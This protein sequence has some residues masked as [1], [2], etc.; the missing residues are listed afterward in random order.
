MTGIA[1]MDVT[2]SARNDR[3]TVLSGKYFPEDCHGK[4]EIEADHPLKKSKPSLNAHGLGLQVSLGC[5]TFHSDLQCFGENFGFRLGLCFGH[6]RLFKAF[7][8][9]MGVKSNGWHGAMIADTG[10]GGKNGADGLCLPL[11][12]PCRKAVF[13]A[14][15]SGTCE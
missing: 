2:N 12:A 5:K 9:A 11:S 1:L 4:G 6:A 15:L 13:Q 8:I 14:R 10:S 7:H 3:I